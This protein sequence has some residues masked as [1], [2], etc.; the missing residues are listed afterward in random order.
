MTGYAKF[1]DKRSFIDFFISNEISKNVDGYRLS[2]FFYKQRDSEGGKLVMGPLWDFNLA[3]RN[4]DYCGNE[5]PGGWA[6][7]FTS[8]CEWDMPYWWRRLMQD[9]VFKNSLR[10]RWQELRS[11]VLSNASITGFID[12]TAAKLEQAQQRQRE[13]GVRGEPRSRLVLPG[14]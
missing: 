12:S 1:I 10:C 6:Y 13:R 5:L 7:A 4:A 14:V 11:G 3:W 8:F 9:P 2:T